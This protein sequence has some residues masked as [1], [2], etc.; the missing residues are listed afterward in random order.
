M[1]FCEKPV[2]AQQ[3]GTT[4]STWKKKAR[5]CIMGNMHPGFSCDTSTTNA[6]AHL[7][8]LFLALMADKDDVL[9]STDVSNAFL[10]AQMEEGVTILVRPPQELFKLGLIPPGTIWEC[11]KAC[12]GLKEAPKL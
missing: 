4:S 6:D 12:Y 8:R 5:L 1:V 2:S 7:V 10:N 11:K 3:K 9:C